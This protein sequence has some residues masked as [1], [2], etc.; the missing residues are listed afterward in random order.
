M[1][2]TILVLA[3][4]I[5]LQWISAQDFKET[6]K[7]TFIKS[8]ADKNLPHTITMVISK[9]PSKKISSFTIEEGEPF[10]GITISTLANP[11]LE[12]ISEVIKVDLEYASYCSSIQTYYFLATTDQNFIALPMLQNIYCDLPEPDFKYIFPNQAHGTE[13]T[14][15]KT[16]ISYTENYDVADVAILQRFVWNDDDFGTEEPVGVINY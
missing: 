5:G 12:G 16:L 3:L 1:K 2:N 11:A 6:Q 14:I 9:N 13:G 10:E 8:S 15:L 7:Y 4:L